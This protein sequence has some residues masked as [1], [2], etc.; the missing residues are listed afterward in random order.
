MGGAIQ[1]MAVG[2]PAS[3]AAVIR[4]GTVVLGAD[5]VERAVA[6]WAEVLGYEIVPYPE[7]GPAAPCPAASGWATMGV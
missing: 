3:L 2:R 1:W 7:P 4:L 5:D 6:F